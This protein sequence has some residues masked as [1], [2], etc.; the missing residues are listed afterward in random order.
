MQLDL[1]DHSRDL[2][3]RNDVLDALLRHDAAAAR[4]ALALLAGEPPHIPALTTELIVREST[5]RRR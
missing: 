3:L 2:M 5:A 4:A 1:F